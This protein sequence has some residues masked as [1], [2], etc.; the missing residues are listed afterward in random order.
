LIEQAETP[1]YQRLGEALQSYVLGEYQAL[2]T[3]PETH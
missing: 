3:E 1:F 2:A